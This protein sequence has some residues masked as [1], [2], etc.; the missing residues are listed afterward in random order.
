VQ[1][2][3]RRAR[4]YIEAAIAVL[5][6]PPAP[7]SVYAEALAMHFAAPADRQRRIIRQVYRRMLAELSGRNFVC[8]PAGTRGCS[9]TVQAFWLPA[10]DL[11]HI[12]PR[13]QAQARD[14]VCTAVILIHEL[15]H[16]AGIDL[17]GT[18]VLNR[19]TPAYPVAGGGPP[20]RPS[21]ARGRSFSP[22]AYAFFAAHIH[23]GADTEGN[24]F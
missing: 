5:D 23:N 2:A 18:H 14:E 16:D 11:V 17:T 8:A 1:G 15:A 10:D 12:C 22:D 19:G 13:F 9:G 24:C 6:A 3:A 21:T 7:G 4:A 20:R